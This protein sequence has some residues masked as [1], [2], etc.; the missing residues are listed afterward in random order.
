MDP[1]LSYRASAVEGASPVRLTILL[2]EQVLEDLRRAKTALEKGD[3]EGRT[4]QIKHAQLVIGYLQ[5]TLDRERGGKVAVNLERFY[6][7]LRAGL[8]QAQIRQSAALLEQQISLLMTV[9]EAWLKVERANAPPIANPG[10]EPVHTTG[11]APRRGEWN[12]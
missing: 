6:Y 8:L 10:P 3:I 11:E 2:Y 12:A 5:S 7:H 9:R 1:Q 4:R